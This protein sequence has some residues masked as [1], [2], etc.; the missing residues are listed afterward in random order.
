MAS[1]AI[2]GG[3]SWG[4]A[5]ALLLAQ[6]GRSVRIWAR[7]ADQVQQFNQTHQ[8]SRYLPQISLPASVRMTSDLEAAV[9]EAECVVWA[10]PSG[11]LRSISAQVAPLLSPKTVLLSA[12][13]GLEEGTCLRMSEI[14]GEFFP[15]SRERIVVLS[16]PNLALEIAQGVPTAS[17]AASHCLSSATAVQSLFLGAPVP[18][19]RVYTSS[20]VIGVELGGAVKNVIAIGAGICDGLGFGDNAKA[21][22]IT[23]G[24]AETLRLGLFLGATPSTFL[25]LSGVGDL[26]ATAN[27]R[28]SRNYRVGYG[29]GQGEGLTPILER[30]G[31]VA[32]GVPTTQVVC[33]LAERHGV[34]MP[35]CRAIGEVLFLHRS[36]R[37]VIRELM[38]RPQKEEWQT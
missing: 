35:L 36:A 31:Q 16:G 6:A 9:C 33:E 29:L 3:G 5:L 28:L 25:G 19:F 23:R 15:Q 32:E 12:T 14:L 20:D 24:L 37:D 8:N 4:T 38:L 10:V 27:S 1:V 30:L 26:F 18:T 34:E 2:L 17:V 13:K 7:S 22:L 21:A 11:G